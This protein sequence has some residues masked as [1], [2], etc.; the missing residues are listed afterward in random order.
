[1][2]NPISVDQI[3][4][5]DLSTSLPESKPMPCKSTKVAGWFNAMNVKNGDTN[6][7]GALDKLHP[8]LMAE[9]S[10]HRKYHSHLEPL[11][12]LEDVVEHNKVANQTK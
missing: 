6:A 9:I 4:I 7:M 3:K 8:W 10:N 12:S 2:F 1:M 5:Q 11:K